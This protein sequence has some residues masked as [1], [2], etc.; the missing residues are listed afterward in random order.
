MFH[1]SFLIPRILRQEKV[2]KKTEKKQEKE[3]VSKRGNRHGQESIAGII[4]EEEIK[5]TRKQTGKR[6]EFCSK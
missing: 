6:K 3:K 5:W 2:K 4:L 1:R